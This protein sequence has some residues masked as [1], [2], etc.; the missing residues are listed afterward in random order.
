MSETVLFRT[1]QYNISTI[2]L[3]TIGSKTVLFQTIQ[4]SISTK[5]SSILPIDRISVN[6]G[7]MAVKEYSAFPKALLKLHHQIV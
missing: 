3:H 1:I 4:F 6:Q 7:A 2:Y 5:F